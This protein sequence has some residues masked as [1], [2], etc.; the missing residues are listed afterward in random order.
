MNWIPSNLFEQPNCRYFRMLATKKIT[1]ARNVPSSLFNSWWKWFWSEKHIAVFY[2]T[3]TLWASFPPFIY[4]FCA[5]FEKLKYF[6]EILRMTASLWA[7]DEWTKVNVIQ[8]F[9]LR[10]KCPNTEF[11]LV[12]IF[13]YSVRTQENTDQKKLRI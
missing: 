4:V 5:F 11:F 10:E 1:V 12:L 3:I 9:L 2:L 6:Y 13:L 8:M 7:S